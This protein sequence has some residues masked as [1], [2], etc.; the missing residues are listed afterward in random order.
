[1]KTIG[2]NVNNTKAQIVDS[3]R[4]AIDPLADA[5]PAIPSYSVVIRTFN[6]AR[7]I[8]DTTASLQAQTHPRTRG[9]ILTKHPHPSGGG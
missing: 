5:T 8:R 3:A 4:M 9:S 2:H 6:S 1:M 7:T